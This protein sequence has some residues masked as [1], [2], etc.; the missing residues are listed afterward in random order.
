MIFIQYKGAGGAS[1]TDEFSEGSKLPLPPYT[2]PF[3]E[4]HI[5]IFSKF[6]AMFKGPLAY[7]PKGKT[8]MNKKLFLSGIARV[9]F[10]VRRHEGPSPKNLDSNEIVKP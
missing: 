8:S 3:S 2:P 6:Q 10:V 5:A 4:N 7:R 1:K 9:A